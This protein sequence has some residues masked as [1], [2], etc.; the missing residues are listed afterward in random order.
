[1]SLP[2]PSDFCPDCNRLTCRCFP[3]SHCGGPEYGARWC[4]SY[5]AGHEACL[6]DGY[7]ER[8]MTEWIYPVVVKGRGVMLDRLGARVRFDEFTWRHR[9]GDAWRYRAWFERLFGHDLEAYLAGYDDAGA[10]LPSAVS[11]SGAHARAVAA[12]GDGS[13]F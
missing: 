5:E 11:E 7:S 3:D 9:H 2:D 4:S 12:L 6:A 10:G 8:P 13:R 1:M